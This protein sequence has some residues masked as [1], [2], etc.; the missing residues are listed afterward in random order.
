MRSARMF[1]II[2]LLRC[3][4]RP[5]TAQ[6]IA[7]ELEVTKRTIYRD[8]ATLQAMR[9]PIEGAAGVGYVMQPGYDLPPLNFD[10]EES[11]AIS[12]GLKM[13]ARTGDSGLQ[14]AAVR[15]IRKLSL[16]TTMANSLYSS[17]CG[18]ATPQRVS[19]SHIRDAI[20]DE[21]KLC[22][23]YQDAANEFTF[24]KTR[25]LALI[26][27]TESVVLAAWCELR[28]DFRHFRADRI[29][30]CEL[31]KESFVDSGSALRKQWQTTQTFQ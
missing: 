4:K 22:F 19:L 7:Q 15:A 3:A 14:K 6:D 8:I 27:Y 31:M 28:D 30:S 11:E 10:T 5:R 20:R 12:V 17:T 29:L 1:E 26:Y 2:Q 21:I 24:R 23:K 16:T 9:V 13:I 25:P 18:N